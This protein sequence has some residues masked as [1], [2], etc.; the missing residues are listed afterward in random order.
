MDYT[1]CFNEETSCLCVRHIGPTPPTA[2]RGLTTREDT[3]V[4]LMKVSDSLARKSSR[5]KPGKSAPLPPRRTT[6]VKDVASSDSGGRGLNQELKSRIQLRKAKLEN[7]A[8][9]QEELPDSS[10][11]IG[12]DSEQREAFSVSRAAS[13]TP[14]SSSAPAVLKAQDASAVFTRE[15]KASKT[16]VDNLKAAQIDRSKY[17]ISEASARNFEKNTPERSSTRSLGPRPGERRDLTLDSGLGT[18]AQYPKKA[19]LPPQR[20][21]LLPRKKLSEH[22]SLA[23]L[24]QDESDS[25]PRLGKLD[26]SNVTKAIN[27]YGTIP[28]GVRIGAYLQSMERQHESQ[29]RDMSSLEDQDSG[30]D[31]VSSCPHLA[32]DHNVESSGAGRLG[33]REEGIS[34]DSDPGIKQE[35]NLRP[36]AFIKSQSQ[37]GIGGADVALPCSQPAIASSLKSQLTDLVQKHKSDLSIKPSVPSDLLPASDQIFTSTAAPT[38]HQHSSVHCADT[39]PLSHL[40]DHCPPQPSPPH[41]TPLSTSHFPDSSDIS[42][43]KPSPR[44]SRQL[45][46]GLSLHDQASVL[47]RTQPADPSNSNRSP[48]WMTGLSFRGED[49]QQQSNGVSSFKIYTKPSVNLSSSSNQKQLTLRETTL[50]QFKPDTSTSEPTAYKLAGVKLLPATV[51]GLCLESSSMSGSYIQDP[52][53]AP[54]VDEDASLS[55]KAEPVNFDS[56]RSASDRLKSC[57]DKLAQAGNKSSTNFMILSEEVLEFYCLCSGYIDALPPHTKFQTRELLSRLQAHSEN[58]KTFT[59]SSPSGGSRLLTDIQSTSQ[60][61]MAVIHR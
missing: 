6:S 20:S 22:P 33:R 25:T 26:V 30:N 56:I 1:S 17:L 9:A 13:Y 24:A 59:S 14:H 18:T 43:P 42:R 54:M 10:S 37:H 61:I 45:G 35:P 47:C 39:D 51:G 60:D 16:S 38:Y 40:V 28:K 49:S 57:I 15:D 23:E 58:L 32:D 52:Y 21:A 50:D 29:R 3:D 36:S 53:Q 27:R 48:G 46:D 11:S 34:E 55:N 7:S 12:L 8:V 5:S 2:R 4:S 19:L 41:S 31:S 44:F